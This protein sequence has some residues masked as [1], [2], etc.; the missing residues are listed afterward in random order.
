MG[1]AIS[2]LLFQPP[3]ATFIHPS[4]HI[5]L[6]TSTGS[7]IPAFYLDQKANVTILFSH[8]NAED[9]GMIYDW[10]VDLSKVLQVNV[11]CYDYT[12]YGKSRGGTGSPSEENVYADVEAAYNYLTSTLNIHPSTIVL[13]GRSLGSGPS[14]YIA[15]KSA[16]SNSPVGG[17]ILQSP[18]LSAYRV[19]FNFRFTLP[20]DKFSNI[21]R[22]VNVRSPVFVVHGTQDEVVP[23][24][25]GQEL[26]ESV[27]VEWRAKP[28]WVLGAGH[29]NIESVLRQT[30]AFVDHIKEF[31]NI[32]IKARTEWKGEKEVLKVKDA[33]ER[34][35]QKQV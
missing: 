19:A 27:G 13:Y 31:L 32:H 23:F 24:W 21:D 4:R 8:G 34:A 20:G 35:M 26:F 3:P 28:F 15:E 25:H 16:L 9:L 1:D 17:L 22:T 10:F 30:G 33:V 18:L 2:S 7:T 12:G 5:W 6:Q 11:M 29:N 14:C